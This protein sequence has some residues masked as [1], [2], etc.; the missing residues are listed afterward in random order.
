MLGLYFEGCLTFLM[1]QSSRGG[2]DVRDIVQIQE[3][4]ASYAIN[5]HH[6]YRLERLQLFFC[7]QHQ[8]PVERCCYCCCLGLAPRTLL[9][10]KSPWLLH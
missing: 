10:K 1:R 2:L 8:Q 9:F 7:E 3:Y 4:S 5:R 6:K